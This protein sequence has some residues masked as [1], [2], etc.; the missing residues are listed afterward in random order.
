MNKDSYKGI[1][2]NK[3]LTWSII[4][5]LFLVVAFGTAYFIW[6]A[7]K[8]KPEES[9]KETKK[10]ELRV[11]WD[12]EA[13]AEDE[14]ND[15][16]GPFYHKIYK[17]ESKDGL[18][19]TKTGGVLFDKAS[20]PDVVRTPDGKI[21]LVAV[22]GARR[23]NSMFMVAMS[24]D[25]GETWQAGSLQLKASDIKE[26]RA[27]PEI[28]LLPDGKIR[29]YYI[30]FPKKMPALDAEGKPLPLE[31]PVVVKSAISEDGVN[32]VEEDGIRY[33]S[34][35]ELIT[36]PDIIKIKNKWFMYISQGRNNVATSSD[37]GLNFKLEKTIRTD[38]SV[39][40]TVDIGGE[41]YRQF[42]CKQGISSSVTT[43]GLTWIDDAGLRLSED[44]G[45]IICDPAP[46]RLSENLWFMFYKVQDTPQ[47]SDGKNPSPLK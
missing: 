18:S 2:M 8:P 42:F 6:F 23:S 10:E 29:L 36:D 1:H 12:K 25:S 3:K 30:V 5:V 35:T 19:F 9:K 11:T 47:P 27:D 28:T 45:Q 43:D 14:F 20:V 26:P 34:D 15:P 41:K 40:K 38:G 16:N 46:V 31:E 24:E 39:S 13:T 32:Y 7:S 21:F 33:Q 4:A 37:D 17:A 22:D 44:P